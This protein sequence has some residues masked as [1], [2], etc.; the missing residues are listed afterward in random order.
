MRGGMPLVETNKHQRKKEGKRRMVNTFY[1]QL[2]KR[3]HKNYP[4]NRGGGYKKN[5]EQLRKK[6]KKK[7]TFCERET[8]KNRAKSETVHG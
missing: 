4:V 6:K 2:R 5:Q 8:H 7:M 3:T 1:I